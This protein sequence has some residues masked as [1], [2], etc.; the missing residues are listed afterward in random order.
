[1]S[2]GAGPQMS[3]FPYGFANSALVRGIPIQPSTPGQVF[4]VY[5]GTALAPQGRAGADG[6]SGSF[7]S[8]K[9]TIA[10]AL[11]QCV[12]GRGDVIYVKPGHVETITSATYLQ[13]NVAGVQVIGLGAG[14]SRPTLNFST[15]TAATIAVS[16]ANC[17]LTNF[18]IDGSG[19]AS[20]AAMITVTATDF[21]LTGNTLKLSGTN[22]AVLG[23]SAT[24]GASNLVIDSNVMMASAL[25]GNT[26]IQLVGGFTIQVSNNWMEGLFP[27]GTGAI[28]NI[29]TAVTDLL[30]MGNTINNQTAASTKAITCVAGTTGHIRDNRVQILSGTAPFTAAGMSWVGGNYYAAT[31]AT[32][33][34]LI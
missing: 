7:E 5:N 22:A 10:G 15:S 34:T 23:V 31:I 24:A 4:W 33:G 18:F 14:I 17:S 11:Q 29:T 1:M 27:A 20:L 21:M 30:I 26:P 25:T 12:A 2:I 3:N 32:L 8:P 19:L 16:A 9:A 28:S 6:N 13:L